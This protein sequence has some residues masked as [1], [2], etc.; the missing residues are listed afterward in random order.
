[1]RFFLIPVATPSKGCEYREGCIGS[2]GRRRVYLSDWRRLRKEESEKSYRETLAVERVAG[3][4]KRWYGLGRARYRGR[5]RV[6]IQALTTFF[7]MGLK[8]MAT[9]LECA[10][11]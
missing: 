9:P 6:A 8:V 1:M 5:W 7:T 2:K 3:V 10:P 4:S 11:P